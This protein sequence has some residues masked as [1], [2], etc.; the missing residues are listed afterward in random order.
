MAL[1]A[2]PAFAE[3]TTIQSGALSDSS[4]APISPGYDSWGYNY[5]ARMFNGGY[6]DSYRNASW[7]QAYADV[8]L[9]MKWNDAWLSNVDCDGDFKLDRHFGR[10]SYIDS[11]AW[12]TNHQSGKVSVGGKMR[13]WTYF[14]K[15]VA[16]TSEDVL[17]SG[18]WYDPSGK[19]I[20][21][22]IWNEFAVIEE[23]YND[24][25]TGAHGKL[26]VSPSGA[27]LGNRDL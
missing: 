11:G 23:V 5:Q 17:D 22:M 6:C 1:F 3:C 13:Q 4:G 16:V 14:V 24:P 27:G 18:V 8:D 9:L 25:S 7:C 20:G 10:S 15:I 19:E 2:A 21:P 12:L 26:Y